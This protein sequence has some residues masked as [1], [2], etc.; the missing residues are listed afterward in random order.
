MR[1]AQGD[2]NDFVQAAG[3]F[4]PPAYPHAPSPA[5][6]LLYCAFLPAHQLRQ[7]PEGIAHLLPFRQ[8]LVQ[9][10]TVGG[11]GIM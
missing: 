2:H 7:G 6:S 10:L 3:G 4:I 1:A 9:D 5:K 8:K 11:G